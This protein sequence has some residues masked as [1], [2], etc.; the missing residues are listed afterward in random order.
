MSQPGG[1]SDQT[2]D[3]PGQPPGEPFYRRLMEQATD[4]IFVYDFHGMIYLANPSA[5]ELLGCP[6]EQVIGSNAYDYH[7]GPIPEEEPENFARLAQGQLVQIERQVRRADGRVVTVEIRARKIAEDRIMGIARDLTA[8]R[9]AEGAM[10]QAQEELERRVSRRTDELRRINRKLSEEIEHRRQAQEEL[11]RRSQELSALLAAFPDML[12]RCRSDGVFVDY[13]AADPSQL[14]VPPEQFLGKRFQEV[15]PAD[16]A[17]PIEQAVADVLAEQTTQTVEYPMDAIRGPGFFEA[18]IVP[19]NH[20]EVFIVVRD[21][22]AR[23]QAD[24]ERTRQEAERAH[25]AR[26]IAMGEMAAG[27]AHELNQPLTAVANYAQ[28]SVRR[29]KAAGIDRPDVLEAMTMAAE[30]ARRAGRILTHLRSFVTKTEPQRSMVDLAD[31]LENAIA[32]IRSLRGG[33]ADI[34][35]VRQ[36][37]RPLPAIPADAV[38]LEQVMLNLLHNAV[39]AIEEHGA[40]RREIAVTVDVTDDRQVLICVL[41]TAGSNPPQDL[42]RLFEPFYSTK[43]AG[44]GMGLKIGRSII[45]AHGG[46]L[47]AERNLDAGMKFCFALPIDKSDCN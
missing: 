14:F 46:R 44:M 16:V 9:E 5:G 30:Q 20:G 26:L 25:Y 15:L 41:D 6:L 8:R 7:E 21:I 32:M 43:G 2:T 28:G 4:A 31:V 27:L 19:L 29:L 3:R 47:W 18:R 22:T 1:E 45:D 34:S 35:I 38:Q 24:A 40:L 11:L 33:K 36:V 23:H 42:G 12:F 17:G 13:Y 37:P 39:E 10:R